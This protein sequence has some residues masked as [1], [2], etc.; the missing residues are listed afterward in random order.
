MASVNYNNLIERVLNASASNYWDEAV[1]EWEI[2]D[3]EEDRRCTSFC[4]CGKEHIKYLYTIRN[5]KT[6]NILY[7]I[8]SSCIQKFEQDELTEE[9]IIRE[10]LFKLFHA[11]RSRERIELSSK[12]FSRNLLKYLYDNGV[13]VDSKYNSFDGYNDYRFMLDMFNKRKKTDIS[14]AQI[15]KI[16][17]LIAYS[18][19]PFLEHE[20]KFRT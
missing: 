1:L 10:K 9:T 2:V 5:I 12:Y 16:N 11:I 17:G 6:G 4:I 7:P 13:F 20:L 3:C 14:E 8:G 15:R 19:K 18:I